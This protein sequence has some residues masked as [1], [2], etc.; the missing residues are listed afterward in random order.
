MHLLGDADLLLLLLVLLLLLLADTHFDIL[1]FNINELLSRRTMC[2]YKSGHG[3]DLGLSPIFI[4]NGL[5]LDLT[6][7]EWTGT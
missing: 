6:L 4:E 1:T 7:R 2:M 5:E 3:L